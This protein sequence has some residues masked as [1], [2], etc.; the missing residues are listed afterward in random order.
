MKKTAAIL[1]FSLPLAIIATA[2]WPAIERDFRELPMEARRFTGPLFWLHGDETPERLT[3]TLQRIYESGCGSVTPESRPHSDWLGEGWYRDLG[4]SIGFARQH[5]MSLFIFD[6]Y[7]WP[8]QMMG[9]R[10]PE[11]YGSKLLVADVAVPENR[12][13]QWTV[14][15]AGL[16]TEQVIGIVA[17]KLANGNAY[18]AASLKEIPAAGGDIT[19]PGQEWR[20]LVFRWEFCGKKGSQCKYISVDG[21]DREATQWFL[22]HVYQP[23]FDRFKEDFGKTVRGFFFDEPETVGTW[24]REVMEVINE[25]GLDWKTLLTAKALQLDG[26]AQTAAAYQYRECFAEAWARVMY[27]GMSDW[28]KA[29]GVISTGHFMEHHNDCFRDQLCAGDVLHLMKY[30]DIPAVDLVCHQLY[31]GDKNKPFMYQMPKL[32]SSISHIYGKKDNLAMCE[33]FGGYDQKLT[34][35]TMK[36]LTDHHQLRGVNFLIQHSFNPRAPFDSDYPPYFYNGGF[37]PRYPLHR[38]WASYNNRLSNLLTGGRHVCQAAFIHLGQSYHLGKNI[39]PEQLTATLQDALIDC[40]YVPFDAWEYTARLDGAEIVLAEERYPLLILAACEVM[41]YTA[42]E[43]ARQFASGGGAVLAYGIKPSRSATPGKSDADLRKLADELFAL[44]RIKFIDSETPSVADVKKTVCDELGI[45]PTARVMK[46]ESDDWLHILHRKKDGRDLFFICNQS[47]ESTARALTLRFEAAGFPECWDAMRNEISVP[48][49]SRVDDRTV[50]IKLTLAKF[51]STVLVFS[52]TARTGSGR[53]ARKATLLVR[54]NP[55]SPAD[56]K[57]QETLKL[58]FDGSA[59]IWP[60]ANAAHDV[61]SGTNYFRRVFEIPANRKIASAELRITCDNAATLWLNGEKIGTSDLRYEGWKSPRRFDLAKQLRTSGNV[62]AVE[63]INWQNDQANPAGLLIKLNIRFADGGS[64][65]V[66]TDADWRCLRSV[67]KGQWT[68]LKFDDSAWERPESV[69]AYGKGPWGRNLETE[70]LAISPAPAAD[71]FEAE[72]EIAPEWLKPGLMVDLEFAEVY[73]DS[74]LVTINGQDAGG[75]IGKPFRLRV[76][77]FL[78]PGANRLK[79]E[80]YA[81]H[82]VQLTLREIR[83][84]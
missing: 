41:P 38:I 29:H 28:C 24:G 45:R 80:P 52:D 54:R 9:G 56:V 20:A 46:G 35:P 18:D 62:L 27:K 72:V 73:E 50:D 8:S 44:P 70:R 48:D 66:A 31:P 83:Q 58:G 47:P 2:D 81:P 67:P 15:R 40:D 1:L 22:D 14:S 25:R 30:V 4:L 71:P 77:R 7:W 3:E 49:Y 34:Y 51:E 33:I 43:K 64:M 11:Q 68:A 79:I 19:L 74:A 84:P 61:P 5:G 75:F 16:P 17:A 78:K 82:A 76:D 13:G 10:V 63:G 21:A 32:A 55:V 42:L 6:D 57:K 65:A 39:R 36:W 23:H 69:I 53:G 37:E 12:N 59:W 60:A 26:E